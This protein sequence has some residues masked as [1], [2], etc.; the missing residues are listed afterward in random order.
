MPFR[1]AFQ[2]SAPTEASKTE[3]QV[4]LLVKSGDYSLIIKMVNW[5]KTQGISCA[6]E[7]DV[8]PGRPGD[9]LL[10]VRP[11]GSHRALPALGATCLYSYNKFS[12]SSNY[13]KW[14]SIPYT[15]RTFTK[16]TA[17]ILYVAN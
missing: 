4:K 13:F 8:R 5:S 12:F 16:K 14:I 6:V 1:S 7:A 9:E 3:L 11:S 15:Q 10:D 17:I 2:I